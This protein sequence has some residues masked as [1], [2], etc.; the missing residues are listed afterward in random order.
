M[1]YSAIILAAGKGTRM[2]SELP[3]VMH[4]LAGQPLLSHVFRIAKQAERTIVVTAPGFD[5]VI[6]LSKQHTVVF[7]EER[8]GTGHAV[9]KAVE[10][11]DFTSDFIVVLYGDTP[12]IQTETLNNLAAIMHQNQRLAVGVL[13]FSVNPYEAYGRLVTNGQKLSGIIEYADADSMQRSY[14]L[15]NAGIMMIRTAHLK[16][17]LAKLDTD[18]KQKEYYLTDLVKYA[19]AARLECVALEVDREEV[20]G[21]NSRTELAQA[22]QLFQKKKRQ[23]ILQQ[24]VTLIAPDTVFFSADTI[25]EQDVTIEP[26]VYFGPGVTVASHSVIKAFSH[27]EGV[28]IG[29]HCTVGPFARLRP[30]TELKDYV[31]IGD[32][33]ETKNAVFETG[34]KAS[35]LSYVGDTHV[36][37]GANIG[38]GT[39][40]CNYDGFN[41]YKTEIGEGAFIGS[42]SALVAPV[43]IEQGALI[44]AGSVITQNIAADSIALTR[45]PLTQKEGAAKRFREKAQQG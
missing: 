18:N 6:E 9:Q 38:A 4:Q 34:A 33:V 30:G 11:Q 25:I 29:Q 27:L 16:P 14:P 23:E 35:H 40:T 17:L 1:S 19:I 28:H 42:N 41:K 5:D 31:K 39:V 36:G 43:K 45:A 20:I 26:N 12:L 10:N 21:V 24:G 2:R 44:A 13:G 3:K 32:F 22:E 7:Q 37:A 15:G 8:L